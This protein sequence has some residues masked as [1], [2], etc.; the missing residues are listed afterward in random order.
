MGLVT[1]N[2]AVKSSG[3][4]DTINA[5][6]DTLNNALSLTPWTNAGLT[7]ING[8][9]KNSAE[10]K[11]RTAE[12]GDMHMVQFSGWINFP[13]FPSSGTLEVVAVPTSLFSLNTCNI[14]GSV[15]LSG[16][17]IVSLY[18]EFTAGHLTLVND[19][20]MTSGGSMEINLTITY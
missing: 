7:Y 16:S 18:M 17:N 5:E 9:T 3:W 15:G 11:Y 4:L 13:A 2:H 14:L 19:S 6:A 10:L 8:A 12:F 20:Q 1:L